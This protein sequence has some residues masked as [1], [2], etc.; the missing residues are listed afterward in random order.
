M[1]ECFRRGYR[2]GYA[3]A[4]DGD[5]A[6]VG[7]EETW[8]D[9]LVAWLELP[10]DDPTPLDFGGRPIPLKLGEILMSSTALEPTLPEG[11]KP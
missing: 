2:R 4:T 6:K 11:E 1:S 10:D 7:G 3:D 8:A 9:V 5:T